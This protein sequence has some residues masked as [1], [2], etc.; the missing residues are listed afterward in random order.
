M[1]VYFFR[2]SGYGQV[3]NLK[4]NAWFVSYQGVQRRS[5]LVTI[6]SPGPGARAPP[7]PFVAAIMQDRI[8]EQ[9]DT[10]R[11]DYRQPV[12][13]CVPVFLG[14]QEIHFL[15]ATVGPRERGSVAR[16]ANLSDQGGPSLPRV[17]ATHPHLL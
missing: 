12:N 4:A 2:R 8:I 13:P 14:N 1:T 15:P 17:G 10:T 7:V 16:Q 9:C 11:A 6:F 5:R 3:T